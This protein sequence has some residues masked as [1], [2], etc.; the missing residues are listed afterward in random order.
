M[1]R[2]HARQITYRVADHKLN[3]TDDAFAGLFAAVVQADR[4]VL[5]QADALGDLDLLLFG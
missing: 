3:H 4:Q 1:I 5:Y 2:V